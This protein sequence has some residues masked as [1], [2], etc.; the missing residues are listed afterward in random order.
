M[1]VMNQPLDRIACVDR[2]RQHGCPCL[3]RRYSNLVLISFLM[4]SDAVKLRAG[5]WVPQA[6]GF[7]P[8]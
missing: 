1:D 7:G 8:H 5:L 4:M 2:K 6:D 3:R